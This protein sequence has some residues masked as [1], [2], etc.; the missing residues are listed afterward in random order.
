VYH[1]VIEEKKQQGKTALKMIHS[2][3]EK[4]WKLESIAKEIGM[5]R[6]AFAARFK[7]LVGETPM[8]YITR[9]RMTKARELLKNPQKPLT[10]IAEEV[11][12]TSDAA[13]SRAFKRVFKYNPGFMRRTL[14]ANI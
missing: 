2:K 12:Y 8:E 9:W 6:S 5:S 7:I 14:I 13:F 1:F 4:K 10:V 3:P 11:G